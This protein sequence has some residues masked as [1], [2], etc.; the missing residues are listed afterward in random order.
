MGFSG[1]SLQGWSSSSRDDCISLP[2]SAQ[3][4]G[5]SGGRVESCTSI[6]QVGFR[7][8]VPWEGEHTTS[9]PSTEDRP[10]RSSAV[11]WP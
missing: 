10:G 2:F 7:G 3:G 11:L 1:L 9:V 5:L 8:K 4:K 6:G